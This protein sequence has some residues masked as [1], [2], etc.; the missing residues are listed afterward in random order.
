MNVKVDLHE[1]Y[2]KLNQ[3]VEHGGATVCIHLNDISIQD[4]TIGRK[5]EYESKESNSRFLLESQLFEFSFDFILNCGMKNM[6]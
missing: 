3:H 5:I 1:Q 2:K 4:E 6:I